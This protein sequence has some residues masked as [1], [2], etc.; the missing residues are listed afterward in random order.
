MSLKGY[1]SEN[2]NDAKRHEAE[3]GNEDTSETETE[4]RGKMMARRSKDDLKI[5]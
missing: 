3:S 4:C 2:S 1:N 5:S